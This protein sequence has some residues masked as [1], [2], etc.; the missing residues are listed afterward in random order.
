MMEFCYFLK[1]I[2]RPYIFTNLYERQILLGTNWIKFNMGQK[3]FYRV[4]YPREDW[5]EFIKILDTNRELFSQADRA[6]LLNDAFSLAESGHLEYD[7]PMAMVA[8]L[9]KEEGLI[10]WETA[11][12]SLEKIRRLLQGTK[13]YPLLRKVR[14]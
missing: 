12:K 14:M 5:N 13:V 2:S 9:K 3:G 6:H 4:N 11:Y 10:P 8:Y 1:K 7:I